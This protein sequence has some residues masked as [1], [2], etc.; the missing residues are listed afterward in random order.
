MPK[1]T[2]ISTCFRF[3]PH[4]MWNSARYAQGLKKQADILKRKLAQ[5][6]GGDKVEMQQL[7][8]QLLM[9]EEELDSEMSHYKRLESLQ[10]EFAA[11]PEF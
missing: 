5:K 11:L 8:N 4:A 10:Q 3:L 9:T 6:A 7:E 1:Q 2:T